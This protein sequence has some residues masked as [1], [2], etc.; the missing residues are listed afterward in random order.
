MAF[1]D[2]EEAKT[3]RRFLRLRQL[4]QDIDE[5]Q[6]IV[7]ARQRLELWLNSDAIRYGAFNSSNFLR[8]A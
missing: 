7:E 5:A 2:R 4:Q 6:R 1:T 3:L 8:A